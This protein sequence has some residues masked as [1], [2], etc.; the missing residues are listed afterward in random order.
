MSPTTLADELEKYDFQYFI[1]QAIENVP[2]GFDT[3][4]GSIIY[5]ALVPVAYSYAEIITYLRQMILD[6]YVQTAS[7]EFLDYRGQE[8]GVTRYLASNAIVSATFVDA[9][10]SPVAVAVGDRFAS[11]GAEPFFYAVSSTDAV[12]VAELTCEVTGSAANHYVGQILPLTPNDA[13]GTAMIT[14][15]TA[16]ARDDEVDDDFR[17]RIMKQFDTSAYG[18]NIADYEKMCADLK[19]VGAVQVYPTWQ[20]G[21]TVKLVIVNNDF[22][23]A[24]AE[25][26]EDV[27]EAID[28]ETSHGQ[29]YGLA[30]IGHVVTVIA[31]TPRS[32]D[33][34]IKVQTD[35][36]ISD[37]DLQYQVATSVE[38]YFSTVRKAWAK[39]SVTPIG[40]SVSVFSSQILYAMLQIKGVIN[41]TGLLLDGQA[42]DVVLTETSE[43]S[44]LPIVGKVTVNG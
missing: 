34:S 33:V 41:A 24:S 39:R 1:D 22:Q 7:N 30:P 27:Q 23:P 35:G 6:G 3:R 5:D 12:G 38:N 4:Q 43:L 2:T 18:G 14:E 19:T 10:G 31:P 8:R 25:L 37:V 32:I 16:P 26:I 15:V 9:Q 28:P 42:S 29:G 44:E 21:G 13:L 40:Y 11:I 36:S 17:S 20:G